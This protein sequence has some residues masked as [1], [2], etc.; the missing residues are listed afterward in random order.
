MPY[1]CR[2]SQTLSQASRAG[3]EKALDWWQ[4]SMHTSKHKTYFILAGYDEDGGLELKLRKELITQTLQDTEFLN[5]LVEINANNEEGLAQRISRIRDL[6]PIETITV[7]AE[8]RH[9]LSV[10][11][12]FKKTF[13]KTLEIKKYRAEFEFDHRWISTSS[14]FA[15][16]SRNVI[17][18][19]WF[20]LKRRMGRSLRKRMRFLSRS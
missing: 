7:F 8:S 15:W 2:N 4:K 17:V 20:Q 10:K 5:H 6:L 3:L 18:R 1:G 14:S 16:F 13:G 9:A 12:I 11:P 19:I